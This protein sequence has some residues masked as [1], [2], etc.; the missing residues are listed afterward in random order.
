MERWRPLS[1][2]GKETPSSRWME[3]NA[4]KIFGSMDAIVQA[5]KTGK[6]DN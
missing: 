5:G 6:K 4:S 1:F 2:K 3:K